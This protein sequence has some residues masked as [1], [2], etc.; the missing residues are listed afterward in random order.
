MKAVELKKKVASGWSQT[1][2]QA[3]GSTSEL[4]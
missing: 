1:F 4:Q 3:A 2:T